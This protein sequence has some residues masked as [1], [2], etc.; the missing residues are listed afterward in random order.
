VAFDASMLQPC[1][2]QASETVTNYD[3]PARGMYTGV[4]LHAFNLGDSSAEIP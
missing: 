1:L 4:L 2:E 3:G